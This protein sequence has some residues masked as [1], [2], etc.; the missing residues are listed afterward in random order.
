VPYQQSTGAFLFGIAESNSLNWFYIFPPTTAFG[1]RMIFNLNFLVT[2]LKPSKFFQL[3]AT[4]FLNFYFDFFL[5]KKLS[6]F[7]QICFC[8]FLLISTI[9]T[10]FT[11]VM[12]IAK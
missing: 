12:T 1:Q 9:L 2:G 3:L 8:K 10:V 6:F 4:L 11:N 7:F 5:I